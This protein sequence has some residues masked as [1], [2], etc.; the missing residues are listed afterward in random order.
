MHSLKGA[1]RDDLLMIREYIWNSCGIWLD[2]SKEY[3]LENRLGG[4]CRSENLSTY[5][6][7]IHRAKSEPRVQEELIDCVTINETLFFRDH[8]PFQALRHKVI[9]ALIDAREE[10]ANP[11]RLRIWSAA[12]STGQEAYS[13][14]MA[15][16]ELIPDIDQWDI[17]VLCSD[18]SEAALADAQEG[19]YKAF[20]IERGL[21]TEYLDR[22]FTECDRGWKV[23]DSIKSLCRF[24]K[25]NLV[26][27]FWG[28][29]PFDVV[30]CRNVAIYFTAEDRK[31][32]FERLTTTM[33]DDGYLFVGCSECL[34]DLGYEPHHH[35]GSVFYRPNSNA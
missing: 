5:R 9:P 3:L 4:L 20:E 32:L 13:I 10:S 30:F 18:I 29:G 23:N 24:E 7:L 35:C 8:S 15:L 25:R 34:Q 6:E 22:Y 14:A 31:Q 2:E 33:A 27:P 28:L 17:E 12:C 21:P 26:R 16:T 19:V 11:N 1:E